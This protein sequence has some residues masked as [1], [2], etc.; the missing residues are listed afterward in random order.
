VIDVTNKSLE[1]IASAILSKLKNYY[2]KDFNKF[3]E[4]PDSFARKAG[5]WAVF[6]IFVS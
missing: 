3:S 1:E 4:Y 5:A 6:F 2:V